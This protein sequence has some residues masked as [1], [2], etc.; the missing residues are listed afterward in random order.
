VHAFATDLIEQEK[1]VRTPNYDRL[2]KLFLEPTLAVAVAM[3][4]V[5]G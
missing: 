1:L 3:C 5:S 2:V 4:K